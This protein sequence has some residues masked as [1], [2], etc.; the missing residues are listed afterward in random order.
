[1]KP[2]TPVWRKPAGDGT[3]AV[4]SGYLGILGEGGLTQAALTS[5]YSGVP[6]K[7]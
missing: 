2:A 1:M 3:V 5:S 4:A 6:V 7:T